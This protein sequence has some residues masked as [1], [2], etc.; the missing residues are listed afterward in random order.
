MMSATNNLIGPIAGDIIGS[1]YERHPIRTTRF[2]LFA[3]GCRFTDDTVLTLAI[4]HAIYSGTSYADSLRS[5]AHLYPDAGYGIKFKAWAFFDQPQQHSL[6]NG[7]AMRVS[8]IGWWFNSLD[9]VLEEASKS[10]LPSHDHPEAIRGAQAVAAAIFLARTGAGK[11]GI[12]RFVQRTFN[13]DLST[14]LDEIRKSHPF[15]STCQKSVPPALMAFLE[16]SNYVRTVRLAVSLGY[17][18]DTLASIAGAVAGAYYGVPISIH[19]QA[20]S[21]LDDHL[22][23]VVMNFN[24]F[25]HRRSK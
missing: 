15:D 5:F 20:L 11:N 23:D 12:K 9:E 17:D 1:V 4:A 18:A 22:R 16:G 14:T 7:A 10:C 2:P 19:R 6:G 25:L 13:Y 8:P 24:K 3:K 21:H